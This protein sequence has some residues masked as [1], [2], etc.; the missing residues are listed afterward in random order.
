MADGSAGRWKDSDGRSGT[1]PHT[2]T[3]ARA[4][5][6]GRGPHRRHRRPGGPS[7]Q[8]DQR[9]VSITGR[10][11]PRGTAH[12]A[13][14]KASV[15]LPRGAEGRS[16]AWARGCADHRATPGIRETRARGTPAGPTGT[17][18]NPKAR[19]F[20]PEA[21]PDQAAHRSLSGT[22]ARE[23]AERR[24]RQGRR[25]RRLPAPAAPR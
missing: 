2:G 11:R 24:D 9:R 25:P 13:A 20:L 17:H 14:M 1:A 19:A 18:P 8:R 21:G 22:C 15:A 10:W 16:G 7:L 3:V 4:V 5:R 23:R 12:Q 6:P